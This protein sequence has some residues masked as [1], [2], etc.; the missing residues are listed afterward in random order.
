MPA[1]S[2]HLVAC[3]RRGLFAALPL[4]ALLAARSR[5]RPATDSCPAAPAP[6]LVPPLHV[7]GWC[8]RPLA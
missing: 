7:S 1:A 3:T 6:A 8:V 5:G 4:L 2:P